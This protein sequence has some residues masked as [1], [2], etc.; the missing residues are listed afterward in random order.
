MGRINVHYFGD[1]V[2]GGGRG[3][4]EVLTRNVTGGTEENK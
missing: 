1:N 2:E 4:F 3:L